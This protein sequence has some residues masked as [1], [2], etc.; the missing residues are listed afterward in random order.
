LSKNFESDIEEVAK[1]KPNSQIAGA[2]HAAK[3]GYNPF[4]TINMALGRNNVTIDLK[5]DAPNKKVYEINTDIWDPVHSATREKYREAGKVDAKGNVKVLLTPDQKSEIIQMDQ[6][7][8]PDKK[9]RYMIS[10]TNF[11]RMYG[12]DGVEYLVRYGYLH[13][14]TFMGVP[15]KIYKQD[16]DFHYEPLFE[17]TPVLTGSSFDINFGDIIRQMKIYHTP[18]DSEAFSN[19]LKDIPF[20]NNP[21][22]GVSLNIG[23]EGAPGVYGIPDLKAFKTKS[24]EELM[25]YAQSNDLEWLAERQPQEQEVEVQTDPA[26]KKRG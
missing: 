12:G 21:M 24:F 6:A 11:K 23:I 14:L 25:N 5:Y 19:S 4:P 3:P 18:W 2:I 8:F 13:G 22:L 26:K 15:F 10:Y 17:Q 20:P 16:F 7:K 9:Y 1:P